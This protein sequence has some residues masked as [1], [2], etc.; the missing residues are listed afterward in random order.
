M[1]ASEAWNT[2]WANVGCGRW[3]YPTHNERAKKGSCVIPPD[4]RESVLAAM[5]RL[6]SLARDTDWQEFCQ[7]GSTLCGLCGNTGFV[8][9]RGRAVSAAGVDAG[10]RALCICPNGRAIKK[11]R[12]G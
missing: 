10:V 8:D 5:D 11:A 2:L 9:T 6:R 4:Y 3:D 1:T 12:R 7:G